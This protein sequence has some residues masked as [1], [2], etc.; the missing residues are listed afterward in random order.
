MIYVLILRGRD[1]HAEAVGYA[2]AV[3]SLAIMLNL[4]AILLILEYFT[5]LETVCLVNDFIFNTD[6]GK[7]T[8][9]V[10]Y[11]ALSGFFVFTYCING[12]LEVSIAYFDGSSFEKQIWQKNARIYLVVSVVLLFFSFVLFV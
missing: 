2:T 12:K 7:T 6:V 11:L 4:S 10:S 1:T 8:V 9:I 3:F 5:K